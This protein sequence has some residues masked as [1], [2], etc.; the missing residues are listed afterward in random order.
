MFGLSLPD[1]IPGTCG[2][3]G[4][5][6]GMP[7]KKRHENPPVIFL[8][9]RRPDLT[10]EALQ[11][12]RV[13]RPGRL[14]V[15][16]DGPRDGDER[17]KTEAARQVV[18]EGV[19]WECDVRW[20]AAETNMGLANRVSSGITWAFQTC[21]HAIILE[22][23]CMAHRD[24]FRFCSELLHRYGKD[25]RVMAITGDNFQNGRLRGRASYYF[26]MYPHCWG[27]ATWRRA[28]AKYEHQ[29]PDWEK[30]RAF[31]ADVGNQPTLDYWERARGQVEQGNVD[32]WNY[33]WTFS[34]WAHRG[35][36]VTPNYNLVSNVGF[37]E[38]A[39]H[40]K[41]AS[42]APLAHGMPF[43]LRHPW[44][45][46]RNAEADAFASREWFRIAGA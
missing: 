46:R 42:R 6:F 19:E 29:L 35:L 33:R 44:R 15:V 22:D 7:L 3:G 38:G 21:D 23:D 8:I 1:R 16:A 11:A 31:L 25:N 43:P 4:K 9:Y 2:P 39:T 30:V 18:R 13:A 10:K 32:S 24:F 40:T 34:I 5:I 45:V 17:L 28:W 14:Y 37:G 20:N 36:T 27:W 26:S 41:G 12:I